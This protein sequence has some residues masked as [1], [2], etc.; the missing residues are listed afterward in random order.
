MTKVK[1]GV[2]GGSGFYEMD[3]LSDIEQVEINTPFG[4]PSGAFSIGSIDGQRVAFLPRHGHGHKLLPSELPYKANIWAFK[5]LGVE[6]L[7]SVT[8][9]G[10]LQEKIAPLHFVIPN[11]LIDRTKSRDSTFFGQ[12]LVAHIGFADPFCGELSDV[13]HKAAQGLE[14]K[15]HKGGT[16]VVIEGPQFSTRAESNLYR[17]WGADIIG[18]T[19][20]PEAKLAREAGMCYASIACVTD[21]DVWHD[22]HDDVSADMV[23]AN[24]KKNVENAKK[25]VRQSFSLITNRPCNCAKALDGAIL[26]AKEKIPDVIR[27]KLESLL[28]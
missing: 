19:A 15:L 1:I 2:V 20:I 22:A 21:Y 14:L 23:V 7:I 25:L 4:A 3:G 8:A 6:R 9:V 5:S 26:T 10:S 13:L 12:G 16:L 17:Q 18:M 24:L 27:D 28:K 11:Q